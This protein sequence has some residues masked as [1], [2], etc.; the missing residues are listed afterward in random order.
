ME[1]GDA[2]PRK[3]GDLVFHD[4]WEKRAFA[5][6]VALYENGYYDWEDFRS[7]LISEIN[8]SGETAADPNPERPGYYEHW[9]SSLEKLLLDKV[10]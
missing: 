10:I 2:L 7:I 3:S 5:I 9:L 8:S 4:R 1:G 6:A